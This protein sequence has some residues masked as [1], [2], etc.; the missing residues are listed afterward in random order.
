MED[1]IEGK[2]DIFF[3]TTFVDDCWWEDGKRDGVEIIDYALAQRCFVLV[4]GEMK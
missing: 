4:K 2:V 1:T 3:N